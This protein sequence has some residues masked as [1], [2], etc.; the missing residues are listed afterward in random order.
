MCGWRPAAA[1]GRG[2][3]QGFAQVGAEEGV[4]RGQQFD[5]ARGVPPGQ[6]AGR[7]CAACLLMATASAVS[8]ESL[9]STEMISSLRAVFPA[10]QDGRGLAAPGGDGQG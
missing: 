1:P 10:E 9:L 8:S 6:D 3:D 2:D 5:L 7:P 4:A